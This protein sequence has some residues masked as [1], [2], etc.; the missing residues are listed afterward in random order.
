MKPPLRVYLQAGKSSRSHPGKYPPTSPTCSR[1]CHPGRGGYRPPAHFLK[2]SDRFGEFVAYDKYCH[3][4]D[5]QK[6]GRRLFVTEAPDNLTGRRREGV[7]R[8]FA[9]ASKVVSDNEE[10]CF[11]R[12][13][14]KR[15]REK[16][17]AF[18]RATR[19]LCPPAIA[20]QEMSPDDSQGEAGGFTLARKTAKRAPVPVW[21]ASLLRAALISSVPRSL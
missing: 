20:M 6:F 3:L 4:G 11:G 7:I 1:G 8:E 2:G 21:R 5:V 17:G 14:K 10:P 16:G 18:P 12:K 13:L 19:H 15:E 9:P